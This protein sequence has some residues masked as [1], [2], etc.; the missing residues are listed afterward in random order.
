MV[1]I[2]GVVARLVAHHPATAARH[3]HLVLAVRGKNWNGQICI[4]III[5]ITM[6]EEVDGDRVG[7][8]AQGKWRLSDLLVCTS[9]RQKKLTATRLC[10]LHMGSDDL[11][12]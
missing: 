5:L 8:V 3:A 6:T 7:D 12:S 9:L 4:V 1:G 11:A 10:I 2:V